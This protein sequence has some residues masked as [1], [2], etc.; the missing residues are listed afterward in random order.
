MNKYFISDE[1]KSKIK[2]QMMNCVMDEKSGIFITFLMKYFMARRCVCVCVSV[3]VWVCVC[4][5]VC[6]CV[7]FTLF[8][9]YK[10]G[11][12]SY[13]TWSRF[14]TFKMWQDFSAWNLRRKKVTKIRFIHDFSYRCVLTKPSLVFTGLLKSSLSRSFAN[15]FISY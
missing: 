11:F 1:N 3:C 12:T 8:Y 14:C 9:Y 10:F 4:V 15:H 7:Y 2:R 13:W 6:D 5:I